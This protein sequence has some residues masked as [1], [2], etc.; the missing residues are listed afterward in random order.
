MSILEKTAALLSRTTA[1]LA[2]IL[3]ILIQSRPLSRR[4]PAPERSLVILGNG[5]SL[6]DTIANHHDFLADKDLLAVNFAANAPL[7]HHLRPSLYVLADSHFFS[8]GDDAKVTDLW[9]NLAKTD[10]PLTLFVPANQVAQARRHLKNAPSVTLSTFNLTPVEG[11][12][13][14][15]RFAFRHGLGMPRPR[16]VLIPSL[17]TAMRNGY[18]QIYIAGADHSWSKTLWVDDK[19]R[20]VTIQPHF[21][22]DDEKEQERVTSLYSGIHLHDI[23]NSFSIAFRSYFEIA[24]FAARS[25]IEI[26]NITPGSF[27]DAFRRKSL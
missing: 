20:V 1:S 13:W 14:L 9:N 23:Y 19:N 16:N 7:Y 25:R 17:M 11:F 22:P 3:K 4:L 2:S 24:D 15:R 26:L 10:W 8:P 6:N 5:P 27:I 12:G 21:Y 18:R